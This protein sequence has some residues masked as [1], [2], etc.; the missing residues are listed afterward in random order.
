M[1]DLGILLFGKAE[2]WRLVPM[3]WT[4]LSVTPGIV[5]GGRHESS[6]FS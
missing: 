2:E 4:A 6:S 3:R 1:R 5:G